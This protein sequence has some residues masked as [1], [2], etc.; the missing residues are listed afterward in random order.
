MGFKS[1]MLGRDFR[2]E[3]IEHA[4]PPTSKSPNPQVPESLLCPS[5]DRPLRVAFL[6]QIGP[7]KGAD[8]VRRLVRRAALRCGIP[9]QW[10]LI[11]TI[12]GGIDHRVVQ[13]GRYDRRELPSVL[14]AAAPDLVAFLSAWPETY[15]Y[16][17]DEAL[18]CGVPV[19]CT[20]LGAP[21]ERV[22]NNGCGWVLDRLDQEAFFDLLESIADDWSGYLRVVRRTRAVGL[23]DLAR[24]GARYARHYQKASAECRPAD[25]ARLLDR[26]AQLGPREGTGASLRQC[27]TSAVVNSGVSLLEALRLRGTAERIAMRLLPSSARARIDDLRVAK[28]AAWE[29]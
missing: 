27:L 12:R 15:C 14:E 2:F 7:H 25:G 10:H 22:R 29:D 21:A 26:L 8:L 20:P 17:L 6:G 24:V 9:I 13:H 5:S 3:R 23:P 16:T 28:A 1:E 18:R 19:I 4:L 11:G